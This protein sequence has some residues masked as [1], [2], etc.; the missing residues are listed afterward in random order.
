MPEGISTNYRAPTNLPVPPTPD[1]SKELE[2]TAKEKLDKSMKKLEKELNTSNGPGV[3]LS[4]PLSGIG[5]TG[6]KS[7][8]VFRT[9]KETPGSFSGYLRRVLEN[10]ADSFKKLKDTI[11]DVASEFGEDVQN[12]AQGEAAERFEKA[13]K[14]I[15]ESLESSD[16]SLTTKQI[17]EMTTSTAD[18]IKDYFAGKVDQS[19]AAFKNF[20][21]KVENNIE[22]GFGTNDLDFIDD[23]PETRNE[24]KLYMPPAFS[25]ND[26][27]SYNNFELGVGGA[28]FEAAS[29]AGLDVAER[30]RQGFQNTFADL[31]GLLGVGNNSRGA[32]AAAALMFQG[33]ADKVGQGGLAKS[34]SRVVSNPNVRVIFSGVNLR[35]FSFTFNLIS[36]SAK[37]SV[38]IEKIVK[39][40]RTE[41]YPISIG[42]KLGPDTQI[43]TGLR[44]PNRFIIEIMYGGVPVF[45]KLKPL[46]LTN[47]G[48]VY[49]KSQAGMH[50]DGKPFEVD[51][52]LTFQESVALKRQDIENGY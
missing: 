22:N 44:F 16:L 48:T 19:K 52:T 51:V 20:V 41:L 37:E 3:F 13:R 38:E 18:I 29:K 9:V 15:Q 39:F 27:V 25:Y 31:G 24:I 23:V 32:D 46:Y 8:L 43:E 14:S 35:T 42:Q 26:G 49:N 21:D 50:H 33:I 45:T 4:Y 1:F 11:I 47:V 34:M 6:L 40:F 28:K 30:T 10:G 36:A 12:L 17:T 7:H 2:K 5:D